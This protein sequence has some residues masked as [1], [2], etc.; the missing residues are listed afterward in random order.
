MSRMATSEYIGTKR[1]AYAQAGR[2][3]RKRIL[4]EMYE[5]MGGRI[6]DA[7]RA[8]QA[9]RQGAAARH[10]RPHDVATPV[11]GG[12]GEARMAKRAGRESV[13]EIGSCQPCQI[14]I[15]FRA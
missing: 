3:K 12:Q 14:L 6:R 15:E 5:T 2:A 13:E 8:H 10:E 9:G 11:R 1:R 4:D 7:G